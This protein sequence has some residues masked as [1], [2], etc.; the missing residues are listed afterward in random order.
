MGA[1]TWRPLSPV[2]TAL[3]LVVGIFTVTLGLDS[4]NETVR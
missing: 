1:S 4:P 3:A 2:I